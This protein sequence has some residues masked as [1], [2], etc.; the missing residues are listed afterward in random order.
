MQNEK[1]KNGTFILH[2]TFLSLNLVL[3]LG[4]LVRRM[5]AAEP[6]ILV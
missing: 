5:L 1:W 3:R 2:F 4:F 6:A